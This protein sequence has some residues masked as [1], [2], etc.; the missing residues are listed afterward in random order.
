MQHL[1]GS[2]LHALIG[3]AQRGSNVLQQMRI[4]HLSQQLDGIAHH[5]PL[6]M[7]QHDA[8]C[9]ERSRAN[10]SQQAHQRQADVGL[11]LVLQPVEDFVDARRAGPAQQRSRGLH[12]W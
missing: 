11:L 3:V 7:L 12:P 1:E 9:L 6:R 10:A 2:L 4:L 8:R 5:V